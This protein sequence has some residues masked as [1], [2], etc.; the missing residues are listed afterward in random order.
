[1]GTVYSDIVFFL[2][3]FFLKPTCYFLCICVVLRQ[4]L[5]DDG[6]GVSK[7]DDDAATDDVDN[8]DHRV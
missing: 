3:F 8:S 7:N 4:R 6:D 1:M 5:F 2:C